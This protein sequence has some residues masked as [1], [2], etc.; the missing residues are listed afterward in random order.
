MSSGEERQG[1]LAREASAL[2]VRWAQVTV[3]QM[4]QEGRVID[5]GWPG[6]LPEARAQVRHI[7]DSRLAKRGMRSLSNPELVTAARATYEQARREWHKTVRVTAATRPRSR[8][9][10]LPESDD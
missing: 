8:E 7:L 1:W 3:Q 6:T 4:R 10:E 9:A 2:G 5:G